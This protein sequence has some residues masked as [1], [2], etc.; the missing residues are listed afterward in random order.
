MT[1]IEYMMYCI[2]KDFSNDGNQIYNVLRQLHNSQK[3]H[4]CVA[5]L[6]SPARRRTY[7]RIVCKLLLYKES[8]QAILLI[9]CYG[10][11]IYFC[12]KI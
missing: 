8:E 7:L 1:G 9:I 3:A 12:T 2:K 10:V 6:I 4:T 11:L 5:Y